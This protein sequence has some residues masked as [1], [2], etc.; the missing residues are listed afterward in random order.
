MKGIVLLSQIP[1]RAECNHKSEMISQLLFGDTYSIIDKNEEENWILIKSEY[2]GYIGWIE[3][4]VFEKLVVENEPKSTVNYK[5]I[6]IEDQF[7]LSMILSAGSTIGKVDDNNIFILNDK[8]FTI[9]NYYCE[10]DKD[11][12]KIA[13][14]FIGLPYLWGGKTIFGYDCSGFV[15]TI[16]KIKNIKLPRDAA[17]QATLGEEVSIEDAISGDLAFFGNEQINHVGIIYNKNYIVHCSGRVR[18]DKID[19]DGIFNGEVYSHNLKTIK[20]L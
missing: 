16:F 9:K 13:K 19:S 14:L 4:K 3:K 17:A 12:S 15:Q 1:L 18:I 11:I 8:L 20:R 10:L 2:D 6:E 7:G 5:F